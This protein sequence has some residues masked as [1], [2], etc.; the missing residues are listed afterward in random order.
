MRDSP[1]S[2]V[3]LR[4]CLSEY[5]R[6]EVDFY[7]FP[8]NYGDSVIWHGTMELLTSLDIQVRYV[9]INSLQNSNILLIDGGG[10][11][12]DYYTDVKQFLLMKPDVYSQIVILPHSIMGEAQANVLNSVSSNL[13]VFCRE[14]VSAEF[15]R[16]KLTK[17]KVYLW[18]DCAFYNRFIPVPAGSGEL[19]AFRSD[20][21]SVLETKPT[22][23]VDL[24]A[25][26]YARKPLQ[27]LIA[28]IQGYQQVNS[29]RLHIAILSTLLGKT[30]K[31]F[32]NSYYKN[33]AVFEYSLKT[34]PNISFIEKHTV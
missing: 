16:A 12:V 22:N 27:E 29:D 6:K 24:S 18:H 1:I 15:L 11:L 34:F 33:K 30:V 13:T 28:L 31:L 8:G 19:N 7:R 14:R 5:S 2:E 32:P 25:D 23:S 17:A 21:E 20:R 9:E 10:N 4:D 26:G 3:D